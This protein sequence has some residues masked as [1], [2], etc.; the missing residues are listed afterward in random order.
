M[1][2][3]RQWMKDGEYLPEFMRDF[4][5]QKD[6][7]KTIHQFLNMEKNTYVKDISW[8][9]GQC[10]VIDVFLWFMAMHGYTLS[11]SRVQA[12]F[13]NLHE[14]LDAEEKKRDEQSA[15]VLNSIFQEKQHEN[16]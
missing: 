11:K 12:D 4:H 6:L 1:K 16:Q 2:D 15:S 13:R 10:Y 14:T 8:V 5:D 9:Q 3:R 7:F